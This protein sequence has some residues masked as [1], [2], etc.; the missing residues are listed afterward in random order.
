MIIDGSALVSLEPVQIGEMHA[1]N[2]ND[3]GLLKAGM[4]PNH[5]GQLEAVELRHADVH[6]HDGDIV[7]QQVFQ[8]LPARNWP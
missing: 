4:L 7:L 3:R 6:Q 1:G 5:V 2:K 8:R